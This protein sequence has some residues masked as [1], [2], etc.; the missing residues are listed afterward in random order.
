VGSRPVPVGQTGA[1]PESADRFRRARADPTLAVLEGFHTVKHALRFGADILAAITPD[2]ATVL[3]LAAD[4]APDI[5][6]ALTDL[7]C[8]VD[9]DEFI[10]SAPSPPP[11]PLLALAGRPAADPA[12]ILS[13]GG[14]RPVVFLDRPNHLGNL[15]AV[16]R[17]AAA[18][19]AAG[20]LTSGERDPWHPTAL[21]G[22]A[23][24]HFALPVARVARLDPAG[25][26]LVAVDPTGAPLWEVALPPRA[27]L[28]FGGERHG[29]DQ[30]LLAA[31]RLRVGIPMRPGVSSLNL[32]TAVAVVLY[33]PGRR[34]GA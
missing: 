12:A 28:A 30:G 24:L 7:L 10:R 3:A 2:P 13:A 22:S 17:V 19:G 23:G 32:A 9:V 4:L 11:T 21:R 26:P 31:A 29:L 25:R 16:V 6:P 5:T 27:I 34:P 18:A 1:V 14:P 33:A 15:G 8:R 20:V